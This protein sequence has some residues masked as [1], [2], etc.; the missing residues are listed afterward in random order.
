MI[1]LIDFLSP[2]TAG[3]LVGSGLQAF[4]DDPNRIIL[5]AGGITLFA[6]GIY[7]ARTATS[8]TGK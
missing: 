5:T 8:L 6:L 4:V 7:S 3:N 1:K 2:R